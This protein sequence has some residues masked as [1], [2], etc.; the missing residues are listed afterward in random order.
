MNLNK[1]HTM[2]NTT[3]I[4]TRIAPSP[5]GNLHIGTARTALFNFL[6]ARQNGGE[7]IIRSEDTD[8]KRSSTKYEK[9]ILEGLA[10]LGLTHDKFYRQSERTDIYTDAIKNLLDADKAFISKEKSND[11]S[12]REVEVVRLRNQNKDV[13]FTDLIRGDVTFNTSELGDFIIARNVNEPLY[14]LAVVIDDND[15]GISH[16]IRGEDHISNTPRQ[17]LIQEALGIKRHIYAHIPLILAPDRSKLSKRK[18]TTISIEEYKKEGYLPEAL[19]NYLALLGWNPGTEQEFFTLDELTKVFS[20][21]HIQKGGAIFNIE[22][23]NWFNT[24]YIKIMPNERL[25]K[26]IDTYIPDSLKK[27]DAYT[28]DRLKKVALVLKERIINFNEIKKMTDNG[29]LDYYFETPLYESNLLLPKNENVDE[30]STKNRLMAVERFIKNI[31]IE[32]FDKEGIKNAVWDYASKEGRGVVLWPMRI[33]LSGKERSSDPFTIAA[34][35]GKEETLKR[36]SSA[37]ELLE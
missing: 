30:K 15:M 8:K 2:P 14:H 12:G 5:T 24:E 26:N 1:K 35:I 20:L 3:K 19:I 7:F 29:D 31:P 37:Y 6:F 16:I 18:D 4:V 21:E 13:T 32:D 11:G 25:V 36:I 27:K 33:A 28:E 17:I 10:W 9:E 22:K 23:L 34:I